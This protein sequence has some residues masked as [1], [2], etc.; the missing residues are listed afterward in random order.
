MHPNKPCSGSTARNTTRI[1][2]DPGEGHDQTYLFGIS[3]TAVVPRS[4]NRSDKLQT[5]HA[6]TGVKLIGPADVDREAQ[7]VRRVRSQIL[8]VRS[9]TPNGFILA[10]KDEREYRTT[11]DRDHS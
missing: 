1:V 6:E 10:C 9:A 11:H 3:K 8:S 4:D 2:I 7:R 5:A